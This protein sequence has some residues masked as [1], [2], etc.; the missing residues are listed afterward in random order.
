LSVSV[1]VAVASAGLALAAV[2]P[3]AEETYSW[4]D[5]LTPSPD[6]SRIAFAAERGD[7]GMSVL[8]IGKGG[9]LLGSSD[10][11]LPGDYAPVPG[12]WF[13]DGERLL[14]GR[15]REAPRGEGDP[16]FDLI[17]WSVADGRTESLSG[18]KG[19][20]K[21]GFDA[22][23]VS[24]D[25]VVLHSDAEYLGGAGLYL[26]QRT[27]EGWQPRPLLTDTA[28]RRW[29]MPL[30]AREDGD[31]L[32][33]IVRSMA[34][35]GG[36]HQAFWEV[37]V[38]AAGEARTRMVADSKRLDGWDVATDGS[39][40][41]HLPR[42]RGLPPLIPRLAL[43][44]LG[45]GA[46]RRSRIDCGQNVQEADFSPSGERLLLWSPGGVGRRM[47]GYLA[48][49]A[50]LDLDTQEITPIIV[51]RL[52]ADG[53]GSWLSDAAWL[54]DDALV[55]SYPLH[56]IVRLNVADGSFE[57]LWEETADEQ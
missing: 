14:I 10:E 21:W 44:P 13:P 41:A 33:V 31:T 29:S 45:E 23:I 2:G 12:P 43:S 50:I 15:F 55:L 34:A 40:L 35:D 25:A 18:G 4:A 57:R 20:L 51:P 17:V 24:D 6:G 52:P 46:D 47:D 22:A 42:S 19:G 54:S 32:R 26:Y 30:W 27:P 28:E 3:A 49:L 36:D 48:E 1:A 56:G 16:F 8:V 7:R 11:V 38:R 37:E 5:F 53:P 9:D 39:L